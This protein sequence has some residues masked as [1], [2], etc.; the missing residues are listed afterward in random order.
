[1]YI[2]PNTNIKILNNVPLDKTYEHTIDFTSPEEQFN[3]FSNKTKH[4][5]THQTYQRVVNGKSRVQVT[6]ETLYDCNYIMF[7]NTAFGSKWFY[8]FILSVEY[9]NNVTS[10]IT[11]ELD[12]MQTWMFDY[13][14]QDCFVE[15]EH[16][17]SDNIGEHI[18]TEPVAIDEYV[19]NN[20]KMVENF[21]DMAVIVAI[22]ETDTISDGNLYD[23]IYGGADLYAFNA[24][25]PSSINSKL[26]DYV[27]KPNS[28][29]SIYMLP[30]ALLGGSIPANHKL[31]YKTTG[32]TYNII[33]P[34]A[35]SNMSLNGYKPRNKKLYTYPYNYYHVDNANG[36]S[37]KLRYEFFENLTPVLEITGTITQPIEVML[38][39]CS[40]KGVAGASELGSYTTLNTETLL[41]KNYPLCSWNYN[42]YQVWLAQ[43]AV[44]L[45]L[46]TVANLG[47]TAVSATLSAHP[48]A[49]ATTGVIS[50]ITN[51]ISQVY[52]ASI[53]SDICA[54]NFNNGGANI[55][56]NKQN[57][58]GGQ[59]SLTAQ[60]AKI[61]D[62]FFWLYGYA[63]KRVK[64]PNTRS[65]PYWNYIK[66]VGAC[67]KGSLP[68]DDMYKICSIYDKGITFWHNGDN[69][70]NYQLDNSI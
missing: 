48:E 60:Q 51:V 17:E 16:V 28:I 37:L 52:Q 54:G 13:T 22:S 2:E 47:N 24:T 50:Q 53:A 20:Y 56:K 18:E 8:A 35:S 58:Y 40:Y 42:A 21:T 5:L 63:V 36:S 62:D 61:I 26:A 32:T 14:L 55:V 45:T 57:F 31:G 10:E 66:L 70:G 39:P 68:A 43:S 44:P 12:V 67:I 1:M 3:Y 4:N 64:R 25:N 7:Q 30:M 29:V 6:S 69:V 33:A 46:N 59:C 19:M 27:Q 38:R 9:I 41:L 11:F 15:R 23:G 34:S 49:K 65:R